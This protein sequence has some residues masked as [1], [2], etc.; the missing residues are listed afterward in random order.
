LV[1]DGWSI[2]LMM[3]EF[4]KIYSAFAEGRQSPL[5]ELPILYADYTVWKQ[6]Q[7]SCAEVAS[8]L[9]YWVNKL[10]GYRRLDVRPDFP[11]PIDLTTNAA[12]VS[13][14]LPRELT[15][16][17]KEFSNQQGGTMFITSL[18]ACM[19]LLWQFTGERDIAVGSP[20]AGRNQTDI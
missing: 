20:L 16:T 2:G 17:L 7:I 15:D 8:Q 13:T 9:N 3:E 10:S 11:S 14:L 1:S 19:A 6:E 4:Q 18:S 12:I 5:P